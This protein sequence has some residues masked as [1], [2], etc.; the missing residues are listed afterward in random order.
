MAVRL[1]DVLIAEGLIKQSQIDEAVQMHLENPGIRIGEAL[2][3]LGHTSKEQIQWALSQHWKIPYV[4]INYEL[5]DNEIVRKFPRKVLEKWCAI[6]LF[7]E[8]KALMMAISDPSDEKAL[9]ALSAYYQGEIQ[10]CLSS[11]DEI[12]SAIDEIFEEVSEQSQV[13]VRSKDKGQLWVRR[14][15]RWVHYNEELE[16]KVLTEAQLIDH[17]SHWCSDFEMV[18]G[19]F[20][21]QYQSDQEAGYYWTELTQNHLRIRKAVSLDQNKETS[22]GKELFQPG[23][24]NQ[25]PATK[26]MKTLSSL[27]AFAKKENFKAYLISEPLPFYSKYFIYITEFPSWP[28]E[29]DLIVSFDEKLTDHSLPES[30]YGIFLDKGGRE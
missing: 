11:S 12:F 21:W 10:A 6:P 7:I 4:E 1:T 14:Q 24:W 30:V 29:I 3:K 5:L 26:S 17:V 18:N 28:E 8:N 2:C 23:K 13:D 20:L 19:K 16:E 9:K 25:M 27:A 22:L 15:K